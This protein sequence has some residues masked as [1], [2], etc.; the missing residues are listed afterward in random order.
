MWQIKNISFSIKLLN[1]LQTQIKSCKNKT[2]E[3]Y[4]KTGQH[5]PL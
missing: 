3:T 4:N 1:I 2:K 5:C